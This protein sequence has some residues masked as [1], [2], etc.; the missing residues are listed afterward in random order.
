MDERGAGF[1]AMFGLDIQV[2]NQF[3]YDVNEISVMFLPRWQTCE[4]SA[5]RGFCQ[6]APPYFQVLVDP[7]RATEP[8]VI[9]RVLASW[10]LGRTLCQVS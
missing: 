4:P 10:F 8:A 7:Q 5:V 6:L 2:V 3:Q 1:G 9:R